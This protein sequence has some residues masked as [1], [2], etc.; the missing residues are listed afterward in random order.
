HEVDCAGSTPGGTTM[1]EIVDAINGPFGARIAII[2]GPR[3][4]LKAPTAGAGGTLELLEPVAGDATKAIFGIEP[5]RSY[6]GTDAQPA[7]VIGTADLGGGLDL[8]PPRRFLRVTVDAHPAVSVDLGAAAGDPEKPT[9][10]EATNALNGALGASVASRDDGHLVLSSPTLGAGGRLTLEPHASLDARATLFGSGAPAD[11]QGSDGEPATITGDVDLLQPV[12][13][14][15]RGTLVLSFDG[16]A[17]VELDVAGA[18]PVTTFLDEVVAAI[19]ARYPGLAEATEDDRLRL[20]W[21]GTQLAVLPARV[22]EVV[23]YPSEPV[24]E[25]TVL[26]HHGQTWTIL[27]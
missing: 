22:L 8:D 11:A 25:Q 20:H 1:D 23:E 14:S 19:D 6:H 4:R 7:K 27:D 16:G 21:N 15:Q 18:A 26:V 12:D 10:D 24:T 3:I 5:P 2:E 9:L 13:L 17:P